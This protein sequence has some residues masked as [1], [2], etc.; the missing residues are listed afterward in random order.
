MQREFGVQ[1]DHVA[2]IRPTLARLAPGGLLLF[3]TNFRCFQLDQQ[4]LS[5]LVV[6][7][8]TRATIPRD[9]ERDQ[10]IHDCF[11]MRSAVAAV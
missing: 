5:D 10:R 1:R 7:D 8:I 2:L 9:F 11:E 6:S 3:S 4:A